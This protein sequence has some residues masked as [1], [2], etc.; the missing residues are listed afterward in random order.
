[1]I[2]YAIKNSEL[3]D[4]IET[5]KPGWL[6]RARDKTKANEKTGE[7][8]F[9]PLW[10]E[11]K[12]VYIDLQHS[13]CAF[14]EKPLEGRI[15]QDVEH[16][17]PKAKVT[18]WSP[19]QTLLDEGLV[20]KQPAN[21]S[22]EPG[23][24]FLAYHPLNYIMSCK[25]CNSV[26]KRNLFPIARSRRS[27]AKKPP[28]V[29]TEKPLLV[30]PISDIDD[31]PEELL[32]FHGWTAQPKHASGFERLR[33]LSV[34]ELFA[35]NDWAKRKELL[36]GRARQMQ[37][38]YL[39]LAALDDNTNQTLVRAAKK[40]VDRMLSSAEPH[41]NCLRSFALLFRTDRAQADVFFAWH[42]RPG[43]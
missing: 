37:L 3:R 31:D 24:T 41:A 8:E 20:L 17:R 1:M 23:Y 33:A 14:C 21:N 40:N 28:A 4:R 27:K 43:R 25:T 6:D 18:A 32:E 10:S 39:N 29:S 26:F 11:I 35:L 16:F 5:Q 38:L 2:R 22:D 42:R 15:E 30:Y 36:V 13:K 34:I 19:S 7:P 12:Q 9:P